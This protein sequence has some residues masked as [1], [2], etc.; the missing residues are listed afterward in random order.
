[1]I[2]RKENRW[3][4]TMPWRRGKE[5]EKWDGNRVVAI[6]YITK[7]RCAG[8]WTVLASAC[9]EG[10]D[11]S[12]PMSMGRFGGGKLGEEGVVRFFRIEH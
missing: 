6:V 11:G 10:G 5:V 12:P 1:M 2:A 7:H 8:V 3:L 9:V 4:A